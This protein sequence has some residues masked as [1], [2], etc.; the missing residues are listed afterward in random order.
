MVT[1]PPVS[2][3]MLV[4]SPASPANDGSVDYRS[5]PITL[6]ASV[7]APP[8]GA[9]IVDTFEFDDNPGFTSPT[10]KPV[11]R[12]S[13]SASV[14][15]VILQ[16]QVEKYV[17]W[18]V[19]SASGE[20]RGPYSESFRFRVAAE[21]LRPPVPVE[22]ASGTSVAARPK[23]RLDK[24]L[25]AADEGSWSYDFQ[26]ATDADFRTI[27]ADGRVG[28]TNTSIVSFTPE[29]D[30]APVRHFWRARS[31]DARGHASAYT[32]VWSF[33]VSE[34]FATAPEP[35]SPAPGATVTQ[36]A[37]FVLRNGQLFM[38]STGT[39]YEVQ[40]SSSPSF[41]V[42][43]KAGT[44]WPNM[45]GTTTVTVPTNLPG[46]TYYWRARSVTIKDQTR[47]D[48][49]S[50]WTAPRAVVLAGLVLGVPQVASP[51]D[52][53]TT[54][55]RPTFTVPNVSRTGT[56][57]LSYRFEVSTD[58]QFSIAPAAQ[59]SVRE[60]SGATSWTVPFDLPVGIRLWWRVQV[61]DSETGTTS[62]FSQASRF[63]AVDSRTRLY[64]L[65]LDVPASC[66]FANRTPMLFA[67]SKDMLNGTKFRL[68]SQDADPNTGDTLVLDVT[69]DAA[70]IV[71]GT[72]TGSA[73]LQN[74]TYLVASLQST[75]T[76][77][78]VTGTVDGLTMRGTIN[79][80]VRESAYPASTFTCT[81]A[82]LTWSVTPRSQ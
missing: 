52:Y 20:L 49:A 8:P 78:T 51:A 75:S 14:A 79:G 47:P 2:M 46:G 68:I 5:A 25:H 12:Q 9:L 54:S 10:E 32:D 76:A 24:V 71:S 77:A 55:L 37:T 69:R 36:P 57:T 70:G 39:R 21:V 82:P 27:V 60:G 16:N 34:P 53:A 59:A 67:Q 31:I 30:L 50:A 42:V 29:A 74:R 19:R 80:R 17:Y 13:G 35:V 26:I 62:A 65:T 18:R 33:D 41:D 48:I 61:T 1:A 44:E 38:T 43:A 28:E 3:T 40:L 45:A 64:A 66:G 4:A 58:A 63:A 7:P 56:G 6:Q 22:P 15:I 72:L 81:T 73:T 11:T 23:L